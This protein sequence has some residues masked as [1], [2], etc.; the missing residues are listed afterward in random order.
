MTSTAE[1][2]AKGQKEISVAE[3]FERNRQ[4]LGFDSPTKAILTSV[5]EAVDNALDACE[6]ADSLPDIRVEVN[7]GAHKDEFELIVEDN[8]PGIVQR[9]MPNVFARLLYGSRFHAIRQSRGQQGIGISAVV[10]Y[11]QLTTGTRA[12]ATSKTGHGKP[13]VQ[14]ELT[15]DTK[16]NL[17]EVHSKE[18]VDWDKEHGTRI[19]VVMKARYQGGKQSVFEYLRSTS[20]VNPHARIEFKDPTGTEYVFDRATEE[21]PKKTEAIKPHP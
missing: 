5:K 2:L 20:I 1:R 7:P 15:I 21:V 6:E 18:V 11:S 12:T 16:R 3:F 9:N 8:G 10:L 14:M 17:P 4:V 13:A 19:R